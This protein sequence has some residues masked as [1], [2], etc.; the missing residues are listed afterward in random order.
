MQRKLYGKH[1]V[2]DPKI[3]HGKLTFVG[4][5]IM[6]WQ[7]LEQLAEGMEWDEIVRRWGGAVTREAIQ[8]IVGLSNRALLDHFEKYALAVNPA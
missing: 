1:I 3:C 7:I 6:V 2:A 5:R 4:T 8:E